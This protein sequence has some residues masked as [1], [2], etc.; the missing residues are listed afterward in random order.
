MEWLQCLSGSTQRIPCCKHGWRHILAGSWCATGAGI[1]P[2]A[3]CS[4]SSSG[5]SGGHGTGSS[6]VWAKQGGF[7]RAQTR[8]HHS[9]G[10]GLGQQE[11]LQKVL[12]A[13]K[14]IPSWQS[15]G[16]GTLQRQG[17]LPDPSPGHFLSFLQGDP[18]AGSGSGG[19]A[20]ECWAA[21]PAGEAPAARQ[22]GGHVA[23]QVRAA[24]RQA[25]LAG[26][27]S[28]QQTSLELCRDSG[29]FLFRPQPCSHT[30]AAASPAEL[31]LCSAQ[32]S[33]SLLS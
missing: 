12:P 11:Q 2:W 26:A 16:T 14:F 33:D 17:H 13:K 28:V 30:G 18:A 20:G 22:P 31:W 24:L 1:P 15:C 8:P 9:L 5:T 32:V 25:G 6:V 7:V 29:W 4:A 27:Q 23:G 19:C 3:P 10:N 21:V